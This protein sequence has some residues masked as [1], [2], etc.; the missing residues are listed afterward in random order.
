MEF[1]SYLKDLVGKRGYSYRKLGSLSGVNHTYISKICGGVS[2]IPSPEILRK[3]AGPLC[4]PYED[5]LKAAGYLLAE[6]R[7]LYPAGSGD[8]ENILLRVAKLTPEGKIRL[9]EFLDFLEDWEKRQKRKRKNNGC[10][11]EKTP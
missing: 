7:A 4:V 9:T 8:E 6:N 1:H 2:G 5:L 3:L 10:E 11:V